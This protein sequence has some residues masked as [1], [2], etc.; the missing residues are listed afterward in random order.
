MEE[1]KKIATFTANEKETM[2]KMD[3]FES[4]MRQNLEKG[5]KISSIEYYE[6]LKIKDGL[7]INSDIYI[8]KIANEDGTE[9][10]GIYAKDSDNLLGYVNEEGHIEFIDPLLRSL[11]IE[12]TLE[13]LKELNIET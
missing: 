3:Q 10:V 5:E 9:R 4:N 12:I 13:D 7:E 11:E 6:K 2:E 8:A 1:E